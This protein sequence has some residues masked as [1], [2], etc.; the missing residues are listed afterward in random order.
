[1]LESTYGIGHFTMNHPKVLSIGLSGM[2]A[3]ASEKLES[4]S[5]IDQVGEKGLFYKAVI[6]SLRSAVVF[7]NRYANMAAQMAEKTEDPVRRKELE[8]ISDIIMKMMVTILV[9]ILQ[10]ELDK[11]QWVII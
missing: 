2:I 7:A 3:E 5:Q 10:V 4:L 8:T 11:V 9:M 6:R 1:M